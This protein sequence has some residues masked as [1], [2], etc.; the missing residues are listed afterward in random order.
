MN[1]TIA[2][3]SMGLAH[4]WAQGDAV[5]HAVAYVLLSRHAFGFAVPLITGLFIWLGW[6]WRP[7][8]LLGVALPDPSAVLVV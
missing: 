5:S 1:P 3:Q 4:Y 7:A 6:G 8:V 2:N